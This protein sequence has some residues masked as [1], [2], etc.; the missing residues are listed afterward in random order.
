MFCQP[1]FESLQILDYWVGP[2]GHD[3]VITSVADPQFPDPELDPG[4]E[5][6]RGSTC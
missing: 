1:Y 2:L 4:P 3:R 5:L 6:D